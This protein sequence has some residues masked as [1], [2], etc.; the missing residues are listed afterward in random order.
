MSAEPRVL[1][2]ATSIPPSRGGVARFIA[3]LAAGLE[4]EGRLI[5]IVVKAGDYDFLATAA[6]GHRYHIAPARLRKRPARLVWEQTGL[7]RLAKTLGCTVIHS[8]HY[9]FPLVAGARRVVTIHDATFFSTPEAHSR[10][11]GEF[12]R[13]WI[14]LAARRADA[15]VAVS[16]ATEGELRAHVS[17]IRPPVSVAPLGVDTAVFHPPAGNEVAAVRK[18]LRLA[19]GERYIAFLGTIE[20]RKNVPALIGAVRAVR[21]ADASLPKLVLSGSRGWDDTAT[22][23]LDD[24]ATSADVVE[25]GYLPL[26]QLHAFL[27]GSA[28]VVYPSLGEGFGLPVLE[29]MASGAPVLT[30]RRLSIPEVGGD[31]VAYTEPDAASLEVALRDLLTDPARLAELAAAGL[32]RSASFTW[33]RCAAVYI[34]AYDARAAAPAGAA[35]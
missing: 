3:G 27:G 9:T 2:D 5:D 24:P 32:T 19:V 25:A 6:P 22:A 12:F 16:A 23:L 1:L 10:L 7:P 13:R 14:G 29:A 30:T 4:A 20:P 8:P 15:L 11:K 17:P 26:D 18:R 31:A 28:L 33:P 34:E 21:A 35:S